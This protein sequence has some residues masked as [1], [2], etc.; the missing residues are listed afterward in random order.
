MM[1]GI[2]SSSKD[3]SP[4]LVEWKGVKAGVYC[5]TSMCYN[6][7]NQDTTGTPNETRRMGGLKKFGQ[8]RLKPFGGWNLWCFPNSF[9]WSNNK[10]RPIIPKPQPRIIWKAYQPITNRFPKISGNPKEGKRV[11]IP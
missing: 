8:G 9:S 3:G 6:L 11:L 10:A 1:E 2:Y 5:G 4:C 7:E